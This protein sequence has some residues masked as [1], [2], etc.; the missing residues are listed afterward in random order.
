MRLRIPPD[1]YTDWFKL[2]KLP[3]RLRPDPEFLYLADESGRVYG[4]LR[5]AVTGEYRVV[6]LLGEPGVGKTTLLHA[7][8]Q[9]CQ[10]SM[11]VAR[12]QQPNLTPE[13][14]ASTLA[15]QFDLPPAD[16]APHDALSLLTRFASEAAGRGRTVVILVDEA[17]LCSA[18][19]LRKLLL[20]ATRTPAPLIVLAGDAVLRNS[21]ASLDLQGTAAPPIQIMELP[22]LTMAQIAGYLDYRLKVAGNDGRRLFDPDTIAEIWRYTGGTPQL[23]NTLCDSAMMLA[24][25]HSMPRV[26]V[27]EIR[28]AV[29][30]LNWVEFS[31]RNVSPVPAEPPSVPEPMAPVHSTSLELEVRCN[32]QFVK[33]LALVPGSLVVGRD[34]G[35]GL[36]LNSRFV[37]RRHCQLVT[38]ADQT[39]VEDLGSANGILVNGRRI[40]RHRLCPGDKIEMGDYTLS[41]IETPTA[42]AR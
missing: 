25:A 3:F 7:L 29:Q 11:S 41:C 22:R 14:L 37:S 40:Q 35:V 21:L 42:T 9:E 30:E 17:H 32:D 8:A 24:E 39:I 27:V 12:V 38:T 5:A 28:E 36:R 34:A 23:I 10:G 26:G 31:A 1:M 19:L 6:C 2:R 18:V 20:F 4:A 33:R 16:Q 15:E 13:E